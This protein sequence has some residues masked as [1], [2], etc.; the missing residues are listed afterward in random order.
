MATWGETFHIRCILCQD[1]IP[2]TKKYSNVMNLAWT[3]DFE[4]AGGG[5]RWM[6]MPAAA[7]AHI[8]DETTGQP[9]ASGPLGWITVDQPR[10]GPQPSHNA[11]MMIFPTGRLYRGAGRAHT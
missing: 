10:V 6:A 11:C 9:H 7:A 3:S 4:T 2:N 1:Q 8:V 5:W